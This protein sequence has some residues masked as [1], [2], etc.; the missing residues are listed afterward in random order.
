[1]FRSRRLALSALSLAIVLGSIAASPGLAHAQICTVMFK[2]QVQASSDILV[3]T[4]G[5]RFGFDL[6]GG[7]CILRLPATNSEGD[8]KPIPFFYR[9]AEEA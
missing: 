7:G 5:D 3:T 2:S 6:S 1:M 8:P 4:D 9:T